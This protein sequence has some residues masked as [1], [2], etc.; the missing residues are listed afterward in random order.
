MTSLFSTGLFTRPLTAL[1]F[2]GCFGIVSFLATLYLSAS[3]PSDTRVR[4]A[5]L[6]Y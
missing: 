5:L 4:N 3:L 1:D 2:F 6:P